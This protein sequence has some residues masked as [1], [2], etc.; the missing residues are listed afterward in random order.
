[1]LGLQ[2]FLLLLP[3]Y[4]WYAF[5]GL[6]LKHRSCVETLGVEMKME[7]TFRRV[8]DIKVD[9]IYNKR[10]SSAC[11]WGWLPRYSTVLY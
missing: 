10:M 2:Y 11:R 1:M 6:Q 7:E 3:M 9:G 8:R 5:L 4:A